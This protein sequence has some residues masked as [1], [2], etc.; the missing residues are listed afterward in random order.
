MFPT[1]TQLNINVH[2]KQLT[3]YISLRCTPTSTYHN[4]SIRT[5]ICANEYTTS[6]S[7]TRRTRWN[8]NIH[9][10]RLVSKFLFYSQRCSFKTS[11]QSTNVETF[12]FHKTDSDVFIRIISSSFPCKNIYNLKTAIFTLISVNRLQRNIRGEILFIFFNEN[13]CVFSSSNMTSEFQ[14]V[15]SI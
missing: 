15:S 5:P 14:I 12:V 13:F 8:I 7:A 3:L 2:F 4:S 6:I 1:T 10:L 11:S 9:C